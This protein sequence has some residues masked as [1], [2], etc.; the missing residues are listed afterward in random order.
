MITVEPERVP[1]C[2]NG[3]GSGEA[4]DQDTDCLKN[5]KKDEMRTM[6]EVADEVA[7]E[8][9]EEMQVEQQQVRPVESH[10]NDRVE[11]LEEALGDASAV[12]NREK[13]GSAPAMNEM[14]HNKAMDK[15]ELANGDLDQDKAD[16]EVSKIL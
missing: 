13:D 3:G 12:A 10:G 15:E 5:Q 6:C 7:G 11:A 1:Q 2:E 16:N 9:I 8:G 14:S 4:K